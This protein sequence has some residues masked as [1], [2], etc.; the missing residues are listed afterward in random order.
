MPARRLGVIGGVLL[1]VGTGV[2]SAQVATPQAVEA[3]YL[4]EGT[5]AD[6]SGNALAVAELEVLQ[7]DSIV[8][9]LKSDAGG[10]FR[11]D[12]LSS[13]HIVLRVRHVGF[14]PATVSVD[15][16]APDHRASVVIKLEAAVA[17]LDT[18]RIVDAPPENLSPQLQGFHERAKTNHFGHYID[19]KRLQELKP[20]YTSEALRG[21]PGV[22][23]TPGR[24]IGNQVLIRG[25]APLVW[26]D[27]QRMLNAQVDDVTTGGDVAAIEVYSSFAGIPA[28]FFDRTAT[29]GTILVWMK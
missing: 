10:R 17:T 11:L 1:C 13:P 6:P 18:T 21:V 9:R 7:A 16:T 24:R 23:I 25:C 19:G 15:V 5:V 26:V 3:R 28:Q 27:G 29:C 2:A 8:R 20:Q 14:A 22:S 12:S 4:V